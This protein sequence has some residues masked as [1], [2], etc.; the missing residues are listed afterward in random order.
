MIVCPKCG[1]Q[2]ADG[3]KFCKFCGSATI[4]PQP[5]APVHNNVQ[6]NVQ[7][8]ASQKPKKK[9][10]S[11]NIVLAIIAVI[12]VI[13]IAVGGWLLW[14]VIGE[15]KKE[16]LTDEEKLTQILEESTTKPIIEFVYDDYDSDGTC[17]A[18]A[19]VGETDEEDEKHPEF[20]DADIYFVNNKKAQKIKENVSGKVNGTIKLEDIKYISIEVYEDGTDEG[21]SFIYTVDGTKSVEPEFSGKYSNVH[22]EDGKIVGFDDNGEEVD[23]STEVNNTT[24]SSGVTAGDSTTISAGGYHTIG[25]KNDGTVVAVGENWSGECN[26][27]EWTDIIAISTGDEHTVGLKKDGTVVATERTADTAYTYCGECDVYDWEDIVAISTGIRQ[28]VG[29]KKDGTVVVTEYLDDG[30]SEYRS[31]CD[32]SDWENIIAVSVEGGHV[33]GLE[34]SGTVVAVG[35]NNYGQCNVSEW[36]DIIAI[37]AGNQHTVG[38]RKDGTVVAVGN[39]DHGEC[40][41]SEWEDIVAVSAGTG[42]TV[43]LKKDGTVVAT[44]YIDDPSYNGDDY[45][46]QCDVYEWTDIVEISTGRNHTVGL[47]KD[48]TVVAT[49]ILSDDS[50]YGQCDVSSWN[51]IKLP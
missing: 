48:G 20:Y 2:L 41:V 50:D 15:K 34:N 4:Q 22:K 24:N 43:G 37:S 38:L 18:Y 33:V 39:N 13:A 32:V 23:V 25:L 6:S 40:D 12:L 47:K 49:E 26:V 44:E 31:E 27:S 11:K 30:Y 36:D 3:A 14:D 28:T 35:T 42:Y 17:E 9:K 21:K 16:D 46:G 7:K 10:S 29:L 1:G 45:M 51:D 8:P 5:Q 19:V